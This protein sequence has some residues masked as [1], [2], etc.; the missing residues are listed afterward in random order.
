MANS[1]IELY[2]GGMAGKSNNYQLGGRIAS[3]KRRRDYQ[4]EM[5]DLRRKAEE[6]AKKQRRASGLGNVLS[7]VGGIA[8]SFIPIPGGPGRLH[9]VK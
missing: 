9:D 3:A 5:R 6:T 2:G 1:L 4:G 7:T 8:G